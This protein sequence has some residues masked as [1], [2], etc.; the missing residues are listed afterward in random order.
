MLHDYSESS[1]EWCGVHSIVKTSVNDAWLPIA[2]AL[3]ILHCYGDGS[4]P[5]EW[6]MA[7]YSE[8]SYEFYTAIVKSLLIFPP[9][10]LSCYFIIFFFKVFESLSLWSY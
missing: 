4:S 6:C 9:E 5:Y 10:S 2:K 7:T 8:G 1:Y 3:W